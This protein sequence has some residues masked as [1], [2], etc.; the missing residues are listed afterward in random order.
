MERWRRALHGGPRR[1]VAVL[2]EA[3]VGFAGA[4]SGR[5]D[6][7]EIET[8]LYALY[9]RK[10]LWGS[11]FGWRLLTAAIG[12]QD[13]Y[14]WLLRAN[15]RATDFYARQGFRADGAEKMEPSLGLPEIR[16]TRRVPA[17][18]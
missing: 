12:A 8:E 3:V 7:I 18:G 6:D 13:A 14:V 2:G 11:G 5:D 15:V 4:G 9:V 16:M 17:P 1:Y 10:N